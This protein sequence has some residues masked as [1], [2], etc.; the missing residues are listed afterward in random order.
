M[1][2]RGG[3][4]TSKATVTFDVS[5]HDLTPSV[6]R[7]QAINDKNFTDDDGSAFHNLWNGR[8]YF[9]SQAMA[10]DTQMALYDYLHDQAVYDPIT[11]SN[12]YSPSQSLNNALRQNLALTANQQ[13]MKKGL[14]EGMHNLGYNLT[15]TR[16]DRVGFLQRFGIS[17]TMLKNTPAN[18]AKIQQALSGAEYTDKAFVS[19]SYNNFKNAPSQ[20][21]FTDKAVRIVI[22]APAGTKAIMPGDGPGGKLG[23]IILG[24]NQNYRVK[25]FQFT[26]KQGRSGSSYYDQI[27]VHV[28]VY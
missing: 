17:P 1:G 2:G 23:E 12:L 26:G 20:N 14:D 8:Q 3:G 27:E 16:Y 10:I 6:S 28:E 18:I 22:D 15:L 24:R 7:A 21:A 19:V 25:S 4:S 11:G 13:A 9:L 5:A